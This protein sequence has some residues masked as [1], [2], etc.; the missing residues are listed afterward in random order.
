MPAHRLRKAR[1]QHVDRAGLTVVRREDH[2]AVPLPR[3]QR[4]PHVLTVLTSCGQPTDS[5]STGL[6]FWVQPT[7]PGAA[8]AARSGTAITTLSAVPSSSLRSR[9]C[10]PASQPSTG[11]GPGREEV[12]IRPRQVVD[13]P[14]RRDRENTYRITYAHTRA[15]QSGRSDR[16][17]EAQPG[18]PDPHQG[19]R[20]LISGR[21]KAD[22]P[23]GRR[24][25]LRA[26]ATWRSWP[27]VLRATDVGDGESDRDHDAR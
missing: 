24:L 20:G 13:L 8:P 1:S 25:R 27:M 6:T 4:G 21:S 3:G 23:P 18:H 14:S 15:R 11:H 22:G 16:R 9:P 17:Q 7:S 5:A 26:R 10:R 12:D 2:R 19:H